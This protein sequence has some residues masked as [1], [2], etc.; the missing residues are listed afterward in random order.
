[1]QLPIR[2]FRDGLDASEAKVDLRA[3]EILQKCRLVHFSL[4]AEAIEVARTN[5]GDA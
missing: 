3:L 1:L 5:A 2:A 4:V